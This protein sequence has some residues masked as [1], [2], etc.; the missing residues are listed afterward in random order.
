MTRSVPVAGSGAPPEGEKALLSLVVPVC[1]EAAVIPEF[2]RRAS[3]VLADL[4][5]LAHEIVYVE[6]GR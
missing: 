1:N 6:R 5:G 3:A 4:P 2:H